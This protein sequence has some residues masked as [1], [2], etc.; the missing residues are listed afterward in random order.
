[1]MTLK[2]VRTGS[3]KALND[4]WVLVRRMRFITKRA[5]GLMCLSAFLERSAIR[6]DTCS[7]LLRRSMRTHRT[8]KLDKEQTCPVELRN[9]INTFEWS[10]VRIAN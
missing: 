3:G 9:W 7:L 4:K 1:M 2:G 10:A 5:L 8:S 6:V